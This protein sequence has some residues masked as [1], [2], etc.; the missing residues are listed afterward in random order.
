MAEKN[1]AR[2]L[3]AKLIEIP[4]RI[5]KFDKSLKVIFNGE[6]NDY[7][8]R[9]AQ[10]I[11]L[12][13]TGKQCVKLFKQFLTGRGFG[14]AANKEFVNKKKRTTLLRFFSD[15]NTEYSEQGGVFVHVQYLITG[16]MDRVEILP[17]A[18]VRK[19]KKDDKQY[20][21]RFAVSKLGTFDKAKAKDLIWC[22][23]FNP[24]PTIVQAQI[25]KE[26]GINKYPGQ[27]FYFNPSRMDYPLAHI[28]PCLN[29][30]DSEFR[31]SVFKN[32]SLRKGF[33]GKNILITPPRVN[34]DWNF[35][36]PATLSPE[37]L[38]S[39]R[40]QREAVE[41]T[42]EAMQSFVGVE[43][44]E[45]FLWLEMEYDGDE[46]EK[47]IKNIEVKTNIDDKL[48]AH[49][50]TSVAKNLRKAFNNVPAVLVDT[51]ENSALFSDSAAML[52]EAKIYYNDQVENDRDLILESL[53]ELFGT[54][55]I[56]KFDRSLFV[57][58]VTRETTPT[59]NPQTP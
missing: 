37:Q 47:A 58:L 45:G 4:E 33:F 19:G 32:K 14:D 36:D 6:E 12:S 23:A 30:A 43:N 25:K 40:K 52:R 13:V 53:E 21:G 55:K 34:P 8:D 9:I 48:F 56:I 27:V 51:S 44:H 2:L 1:I 59:Q 17:F 29:D 20:T 46:I 39:L 57:P 15:Y 18:S 16:E 41:Q 24:E 42:T 31:A 28:H 22:Y 7:P 10:T 26:G 50:E 38:V 35:A 3:F 54:G 49:T 5:M 11:P